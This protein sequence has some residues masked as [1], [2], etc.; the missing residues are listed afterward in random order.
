MRGVGRVVAQPRQHV[1]ER[2]VGGARA[3]ALADSTGR[4]TVSVTFT[5]SRRTSAKPTALASAGS[6]GGVD[7]ASVRT[8]NERHVGGGEVDPLACGCERLGPEVDA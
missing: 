5:S 3:D 6:N 7:V 8:V 1:V 2:V 4:R